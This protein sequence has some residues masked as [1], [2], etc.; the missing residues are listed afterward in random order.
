M[1][2]AQAVDDLLNQP[3]LIR[4]VV[5]GPLLG[6]EPRDRVVVEGSAGLLLGE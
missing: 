5:L 6:A 1:V 4:H 2:E 3:C